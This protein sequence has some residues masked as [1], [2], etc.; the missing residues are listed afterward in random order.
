MKNFR[1]CFN[2]SS[3]VIYPF[4]LK[5]RT[6]ASVSYGLTG[7]GEIVSDAQVV[8]MSQDLRGPWLQPDMGCGV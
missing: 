8:L 7:L 6:V 1:L 3:I 4:S 2:T 5:S